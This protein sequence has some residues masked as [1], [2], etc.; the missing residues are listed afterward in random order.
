MK[1]LFINIITAVTLCSL[2]LILSGCESDSI[3]GKLVAQVGKREIHAD[4]FAF[5]YE[6][7]PRQTTSKPK[8]EARREVL[9]R[10]TNRILLAQE[11]ENLNLDDDPIVTR[12]LDYYLQSSV[13]RQLFLKHVRQPLEVLE[14]EERKAYQRSKTT[15]FVQHFPIADYD[16]MLAVLQGTQITR[17]IPIHPWCETI[18]LPNGGTGDKISWNDVDQGIEEILYNL[19]P[20]IFSEPQYYSGKYHLF[21]MVDKET[22]VFSTESDFQMQRQSLV[23]RI[24]KRKEKLASATFVLKIM[25]P[26]NL[27][28]KI[29]ALNGLTSHIWNNRPEKFNE[30]VQ[31][32]TQGEIQLIVNE[33]AD[34]SQMPIAQFKAGEMTV[35]DFLFIYKLNPQ[36]ISYESE[37]ILREYLKNI[38]ADYVRDFVLGQQ[39]IAEGLASS[40]DVK[41]DVLKQKENLLSDRRLQLLSKEFALTD[42]DPQRRQISFEEQLNRHLKGLAVTIPIKIYEDN[43]ITVATTDEGLSRKIDFVAIQGH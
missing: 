30:D 20:G 38:T 40:D 22:T 2:S 41:L 12:A 29:D 7:A 28:I 37:P 24:M 32:I 34:L 8:V 10:M 9:Q 3:S 36:K 23:G 13:C 17:H 11:A 42:E 16:E 14:T 33:F 26:Q 35:D 6:L 19:E 18:S 15:L 43:L 4:E 1:R 27:L 39:G 5:A 31:F 21:R 25:G